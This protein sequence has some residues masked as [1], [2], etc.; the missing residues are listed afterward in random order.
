VGLALAFALFLQVSSPA[1]PADE[2]LRRTVADYVGLYKSE[3]LD[4]WRTL[5]LPSF[6]ATHTLADGTVRVRTLDEFFAS[7]RGYLGTGRAIR[8]DLQN[9]RFDR[10]GKLATAWADFVLTE[11][12]EKS[13][14]KL[15]LLLVADRGEWKIQA[16]M[17]SY[18]GE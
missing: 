11:E 13:R 12:G 17:F 9:V 15:I 5:F 4:R 18:D 7:Q 14:G 1:P 2:A 3:T 10:R 6:T 8:E 16:L